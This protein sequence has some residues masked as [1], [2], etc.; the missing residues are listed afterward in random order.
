MHDTKSVSQGSDADEMFKEQ[1][2]M[3]KYC[4]VVITKNVGM[5]LKSSEINWSKQKTSPIKFKNLSAKSQSTQIF[6][7]GF[8]FE[9][10]G[11][12]GLDTEC[13]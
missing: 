12:G 6:N 11:I 1:P 3:G 2:S 13:K 5:F 10:L 8:T 4:W 7:P 9:K